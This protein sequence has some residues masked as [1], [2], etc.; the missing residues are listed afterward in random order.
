M[1]TSHQSK[2]SSDLRVLTIN[3][4]VFYL[5]LN[6]TWSCSE[7]QPSSLND[8]ADSILTIES[9]QNSI[10][11]GQNE[12]GYPGVGA[13]TGRVPGYGYIGSFCTGT[14]ITS[15]WVLTAAHCLLESGDQG[16]SPAPLNT[17]FY[18]GTNANP[19][20]F[21][22]EPSGSFYNVD[23][24]VVHPNY[25]D[26]DL[27]D[28]IAL[29]HLSD[30]VNGVETY[31]FNQYN[32]NQYVGSSVFYVGYGASDG[33]NQTG[34]GVK[35]STNISINQVQQLQYVSQYNGSGT[36]FGDSGGPGLLNIQGQL[37]IV[38][39][40]SAVAGNVPCEEYFISTRVD[41]YAPWI[42]QI[43]G[44]PPPNCNQLSGVCLC[45]N[46]CQGNGSCNNDLCQTL[47]CGEAY[48]CLI[49]CGENQGCQSQCYAEGTPT[50]IQQLDNLFACMNSRCGQQQGDAFQSCVNN[51]CGNELG[52]C[53]PREYGNQNCAQMS[54]CIYACSGNDS[55]CQQECLSQGTMT[56]QESFIE[57]NQCFN[58]QCGNVS[59][60][61]FFNCVSNQCGTEYAAC[62]PPDDCD[63]RGGDCGQGQ[64]C[65]VG[66]GGY[67]YCYGSQD[68]N[69]GSS[70]DQSSSDV[71]AC[72]DGS[73]CF[74]NICTS[75]CRA[76][77]DCMMGQECVGPIFDNDDQTGICASVE[78]ID[79]DGDG[80]CATEDCNDQDPTLSAA[81]DERC[82]DAQD[83]D[84]D[85]QIDES[86]DNCID[87]DGD[88]YCANTNDCV[89]QDPN[90]TPVA[91]ELCGD[92]ID[93]N[94]DGLIDVDCAEVTDDGG[95]VIVNDS[96]PE[97]VITT[98]RK[99]EPSCSNHRSS[100]F[101]D[102]HILALFMM[103]M[104]MRRR[105]V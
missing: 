26:S 104:M 67:T 3:I 74:E 102:L 61:E 15:E 32:L 48:E 43:L 37:R 49:D 16:F 14:L 82:G 29:M 1:L 64:A 19:T 97:I 10:V 55:T 5:I 58:D 52:A 79:A 33:R 76:N 31:D 84:C 44:A 28:D 23:R 27:Q 77:T 91:P 86:C 8:S 83:N 94:C 92:G 20:R 39:V 6:M 56:A 93:N 99:S 65:Y 71:L 103:G 42:N 30:P 81:S 53:F 51:Q 34:A 36:C 78:C 59:E 95:P 11:G 60:A 45:D 57:L 90:I 46:A 68:S 22:Q 105:L 35:R 69:V 87:A 100:N 47:S 73:V 88:G 21:G 80:V 70:C 4:F 62:Y 66:L 75:M 54:E 72:V 2:L 17:R 96:Q 13:L 25:D 9:Q 24:F 40:N 85:G 12:S 7:Q 18:I 50:G 63:L 101:S 98:G 38:G 41:S 89:D